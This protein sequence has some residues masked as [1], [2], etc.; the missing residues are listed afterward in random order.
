MIK[1]LYPGSFCP[2]TKGHMDIINQAKT[3][4]DEIVIAVLI[5]NDKK[6]A[7]FDLDERINMIKEIYKN[8]THIKVVTG[9]CTV[10]IASEYD[11]KAIIRG[12]RNATD[13]EYEM[14]ISQINKEISKDKINTVLF[15][16]NNKYRYV[17]SS[18]VRELF[19]L[20]KDI[21]PYVDKIVEK[22][23]IKKKMVECN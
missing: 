12:V 20:D 21:S 7:M 3:L 9:N 13:F 5:N 23:M 15:L 11:C 16:T 4:F 2:I 8:D 14:N 18:M 17:S 10:D 1:G 19:T 6:N 22:E